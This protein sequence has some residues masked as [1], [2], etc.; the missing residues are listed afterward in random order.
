MIRV[1]NSNALACSTKL[2][3]NVRKRATCI[4]ADAG[5]SRQANDDNERKH[6]RILDSGWSIFTLQKT[7]QLQGEIFHRV[8][9]Q[10]VYRLYAVRNE[11]KKIP[12]NPSDF[13]AM[14]SDNFWALFAESTASSSVE[15]SANET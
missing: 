9:L 5:N 12:R 2:S 7:L 4:L 6:D 11:H 1:M 15:G 3:R 10:Q 8:T 13:I 14:I